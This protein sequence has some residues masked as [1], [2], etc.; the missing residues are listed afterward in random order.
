MTSRI[1]VLV[2][3]LAT[4]ALSPG[5]PAFAEPADGPVLLRPLGTL[6]IGWVPPQATARTRPLAVHPVKARVDYGESGAQY[7]ADRGGRMH[8]GQ[9]V[10]AP[11]GTPL[12]AV[13]GG[14]VLETGSDGGRGNYL[15]LWSPEA[16]ET[17]V[18]LHLLEP[19]PLKRGQ[20]LRAGDRVGRLGCTGSCS[21]DHLHF[22]VRRGRSLE[23]PPR[24]PRRLLQRLSTP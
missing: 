16:R 24:D 10:F 4:L 14:V 12:V 20:R 23:A 6:E 18:Y 11:A 17:Y 22:E 13:R 7:G 2:P 1:R 19:A 3:A 5:G 8:E 15:A 21:G 9:D